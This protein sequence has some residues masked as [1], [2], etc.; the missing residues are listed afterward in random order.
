VARVEGARDAGALVLLCTRPAVLTLV[1]ASAVPRVLRVGAAVLPW[2]LVAV[3]ASRAD[4]RAVLRASPR[5]PR[6][7]ARAALRA[8]A[9]AAPSRVV[10]ALRTVEDLRTDPGV[11]ARP[12]RVGRRCGVC[13]GS[14]SAHFKT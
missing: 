11:L 9:R 13:M 12:S 2:V 7:S 10:G 1:G 3:G 14:I 4:P 5:L 6:A 8:S